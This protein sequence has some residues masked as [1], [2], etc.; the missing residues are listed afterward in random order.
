MAD[1][2]LICKAKNFKNFIFTKEE[3][4]V[5]EIE[6][7]ELSEGDQ[8]IRVEPEGILKTANREYIKYKCNYD[9]KC[10]KN[11]RVFGQNFTYYFE[12]HQFY[13]YYHAAS[14]M[15]FIGETKSTSLEFIKDIHKYAK[16]N[17]DRISVDY[18]KALSHADNVSGIWIHVDGM[19]ISSQA[20]FGK[21][22]DME[23]AVI[24]CI[25]EEIVTSAN[26]YFTLNSL[27]YHLGI[28]ING[29]LRFMKS[30]DDLT[31]SEKLEV[32]HS[33]YSEYL[34]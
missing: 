13:S 31:V 33:I 1:A 5:L 23:Q 29:N 21:N 26:C 27:Q 7:L 18:K 19:R 6:G 20:Y 9:L 14:E 4:Q 12:Q 28:G 30:H 32:I 22:V 17:I 34:T 25:N 24:R 15:L 10:P 16:V 11:G 8:N 2:F 3:Q